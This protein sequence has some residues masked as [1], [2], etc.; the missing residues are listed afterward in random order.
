MR[1][2]TDEKCVPIKSI[3][4]LKNHKNPNTLKH[5]AFHT[6][7][8]NWIANKAGF[9]A[10]KENENGVINLVFKKESKDVFE[11]G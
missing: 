9:I 5:V 8:K 7:R 11:L 2:L 3:T 1:E 10:R 6:K 4:R